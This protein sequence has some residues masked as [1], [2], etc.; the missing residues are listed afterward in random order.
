MYPAAAP[1]V[2][3]KRIAADD[4]FEKYLAPNYSRAQ[5]LQ[6]VDPILAELKIGKR[7]DRLLKI[8]VC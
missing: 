8:A 6:Y 2:R 5:S 1:L 3:N 7:S 4:P